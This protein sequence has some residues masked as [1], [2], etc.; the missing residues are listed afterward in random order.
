MQSII[1]PSLYEA[2][3]FEGV[4]ICGPGTFA[5][6]PQTDFEKTGTSGII[7]AL[8]GFVRVRGRIW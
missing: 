2:R 6:I 7:D 4:I 1:A 5:H 3:I 8:I